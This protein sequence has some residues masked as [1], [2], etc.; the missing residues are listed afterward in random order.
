MR[1]ILGET[2][3]F[4]MKMPI[5]LSVQDFTLYFWSDGVHFLPAEMGLLM[6]ECG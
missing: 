2:M 6:F 3:I 5:L 4:S 1:H